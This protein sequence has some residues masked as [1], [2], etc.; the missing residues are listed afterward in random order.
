[1][2]IVWECITLLL[3]GTG[4]CAKWNFSP[5]TLKCQ[6]PSSYF[7]LVLH[8]LRRSKPAEGTDSNISHNNTW[9]YISC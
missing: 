4:L 7:E 2:L 3:V 9:Q 6:V 8:L 5:F 1:M